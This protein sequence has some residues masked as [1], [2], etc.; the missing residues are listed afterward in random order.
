MIQMI[1]DPVVASEVM[2]LSVSPSTSFYV[3]RQYVGG[4]DNLTRQI[5]GDPVVASVVMAS[6]VSPS[7]SFYVR[8]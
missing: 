3:R 5:I 8:R 2:V 7:T 6:T 1:G 4:N